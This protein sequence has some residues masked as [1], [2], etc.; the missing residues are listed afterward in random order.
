MHYQLLAATV[1]FLV[2]KKKCQIARWY[3]KKPANCQMWC[4]L[5]IF[6]TSLHFF[7]VHP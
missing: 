5:M 6:I 3:I 2:R 4:Q 1:F 7:E